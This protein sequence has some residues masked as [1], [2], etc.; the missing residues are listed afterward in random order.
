MSDNRELNDNELSNVSGGYTEADWP[1]PKGAKVSYRHVVFGGGGYTVTGT[2]IECYMSEGKWK[3]AI[4]NEYGSRE[5][6]F[7]SVVSLA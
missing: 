3:V 7:A 4:Q 2:V 6:K 1:F 5:D